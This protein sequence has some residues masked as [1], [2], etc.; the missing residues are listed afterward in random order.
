MMHNEFL[1]KRAKEFFLFAKRSFEEG[2]YNLSVF[3]AEQACQL[4]LKYL[5]YL[6]AGDYPKTHLLTILMKELRKA[7]EKEEIERFIRERSIE[8]QAL[9]SAYLNSRYLGKEYDK[10]E[11]EALI[12]FAEK[13]IIFLE[14]IS[15]EKLL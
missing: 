7:Y 14:K 8:L 15:N 5:L 2:F 9:E 1:N 12:L 6:K 10:N 3:H 11:A 13:L 4:F